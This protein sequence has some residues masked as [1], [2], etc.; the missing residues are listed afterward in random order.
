MHEGWSG[1]LYRYQEVALS[2]D[3]LN[4]PGVA[5]YIVFNDKTVKYFTVRRVARDRAW[6]IE[7]RRGIEEAWDLGRFKAN[8]VARVLG[9]GFDDDA[10]SAVMPRNPCAKRENILGRFGARTHL[11]GMRPPVPWRRFDE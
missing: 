5:Y 8:A 9:S 4:A 1:R 10:S 6:E 3:E 11:R 7:G 2:D